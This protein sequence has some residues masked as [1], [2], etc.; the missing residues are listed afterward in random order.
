[1]SSATEEFRQFSA[2]KEALEA[3]KKA[4]AKAQKAG[5]TTL[6]PTMAVPQVTVPDESPQWIEIIKRNIT[7]ELAFGDFVIRER[8]LEIFGVTF[9]LARGKHV[10]QAIVDLCKEGVTTFDGVTRKG[11]PKLQARTVTRGP[12]APPIRQRPQSA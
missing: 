6:A 12:K 11:D 5:Q 2:Q 7:E 8:I 1:V 10:R 9:G 4:A 3:A